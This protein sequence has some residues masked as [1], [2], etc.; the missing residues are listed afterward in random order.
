MEVLPK[1]FRP[2][3]NM[4]LGN[5]EAKSLMAALQV[6]C[7]NLYDQRPTAIFAAEL[8]QKL[9][10]ALDAENLYGADQ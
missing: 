1:M 5:A 3:V 8:K 4:E 6:A 9:Q 7:D 10:E 2:G